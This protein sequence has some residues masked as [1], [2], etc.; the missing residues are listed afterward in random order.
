[1]WL[2]ISKE[3]VCYW[4]FIKSCWKLSVVLSFKL[5]SK[6][7]CNVN[8]RSRFNVKDYI[9]ISSCLRDK[10]SRFWTTLNINSFGKFNFFKTVGKQ[11]LLNWTPLADK[12]KSGKNSN[13]P[14]LTLDSCQNYAAASAA[15]FLVTL[16]IGKTNQLWII[17]N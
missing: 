15:C 16:I 11:F 8:H 1:M 3:A 9:L 6:L 2:M 12:E 4:D 13:E 17:R 10:S 7:I 14:R 5:N